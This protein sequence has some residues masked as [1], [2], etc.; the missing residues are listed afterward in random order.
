MRT[1]R[2]HHQ[3][4]KPPLRPFTPSLLRQQTITYRTIRNII[5]VLLLPQLHILQIQDLK[6]QLSH[7]I[8]ILIFQ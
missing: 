2:L 8:L 7:K 1:I 5:P 6:R 4:L 3:L